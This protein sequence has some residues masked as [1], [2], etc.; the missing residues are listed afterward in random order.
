MIIWKIE[1]IDGF[2]NS[3]NTS[4]PNDQIKKECFQK[5]YRPEKESYSRSAIRSKSDAM[6]KEKTVCIGYLDTFGHCANPHVME[7]IHQLG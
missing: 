6:E 1:N 7:W 2:S 3:E 4:Y 5:K